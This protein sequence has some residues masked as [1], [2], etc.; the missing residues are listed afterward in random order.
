MLRGMADTAEEVRA[1]EPAENKPKKDSFWA[2]FTTADMRT[3]VVTVVGTV[4]GTI[5]TVAVVAIAIAILHWLTF[6]LSRGDRL[7]FLWIIAGIGFV[8][9]GV[10]TYDARQAVATWRE[11]GRISRLHLQWALAGAGWTVFCGL[12]LLGVASGIK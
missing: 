7:A 5:L 10:A 9:V 4:A 2:S 8:S 3:L 6:G 11:T 1:S 12:V